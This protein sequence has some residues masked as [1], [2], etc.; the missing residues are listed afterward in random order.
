MRAGEIGALRVGR[1]D[2]LR[3]RVEIVE[4][5]A[6]E[7]G[8]GLVFGPPKTYQRRSVTLPRFLFNELGGQGAHPLVVMKRLGHSSI[9]VTMNICGPMFPALDESVTDGL[10]SIW[11]TVRDQK[12]AAAG[13]RLG[14]VARGGCAVRVTTQAMT[15]TAAMTTATIAMPMSHHHPAPLRWSI[16]RPWSQSASNATLIIPT[17]PFRV[18]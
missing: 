8:R 14:G 11:R 13:A 5:L 15:T 17:T 4:S 7:L 3:G 9:T 10:D 18:Q 2:L 6:E 1:L 16:M 12:D